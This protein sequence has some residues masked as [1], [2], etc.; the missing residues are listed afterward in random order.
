MKHHLFRLAVVLSLT[1]MLFAFAV[2]AFASP[3]LQSSL[4]IPVTVLQNANL[5]AGPG[6]GFAIVGKAAAGSTLDIVDC[7]AQ[8]DWLQTE[9]GEWIAAFLVALSEPR[10]TVPSVPATPQAQAPCA[11]QRVT[12]NS[13]ANL[14]QGPGTS[15]AI[16]GRQEPGRTIEIKARNQAG[17]WFQLTGGEWIFGNLISARPQCLPTGQTEVEVPTS[18][19]ARPQCDPSYPDVCIAP[20]PPDLDC[21]QVPYTSF[22]VVGADPHNLDGN[23]DGVA[24]EPAPTPIPPP[25]AIVTRSGNC[26]PSYPDVCIPPYPPDLD[27][28]QI[29]FR[30][31]RVIGADMHGFDGDGDGVGCESN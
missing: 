14:R 18:T 7:N 12:V 26:D 16:V 2:P 24:C 6:T 20:P 31:F 1:V 15:F 29:N 13:A 5:R 17:D 19:P 28:G 10:T 23:K 9:T 22:R 3:I 8:C 30:R 27:C 21:A 25:P 4:P 11:P